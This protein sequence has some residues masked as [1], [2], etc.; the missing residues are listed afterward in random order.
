VMWLNGPTQWED[1]KIGKKHKK[2]LKKKSLH[3]KGDQGST[4]SSKKD[5]S[6]PG[7]AD[8]S[9][10]KITEGSDVILET[11][12]HQELS[13]SS[14][15]NWQSQVSDG[16]TIAYSSWQ[17]AGQY[18]AWS[19]D[20]QASWSQSGWVDHS[21]QKQLGGE[22]QSAWASQDLQAS[23]DYKGAS[24]EAAAF[25]KGASESVPLPARPPSPPITVLKPY[26]CPGCSKDFA[27][28]TVCLNHVKTTLVCKERSPD[29][30]TELQ[31]KCKAQAVLLTALQ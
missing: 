31:A 15:A 9:D 30:L 1:H 20:P 6:P 11:P 23:A 14:D 8:K 16:R 13:L 5:R 2:N 12:Q 10:S 22:S 4:V 26:A 25:E 7:D 24:D 27:K 19:A 17:Y 3:G 29:D 18:D 28:W 21:Q